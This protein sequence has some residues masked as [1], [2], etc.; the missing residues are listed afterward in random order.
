MRTAAADALVVFGVTGDLAHKKIFPALQGLVRHGM[1]DVPVIG[2][3]RG[4]SGV[5]GLRERIRDSLEASED[6]VDDAA[7]SRLAKLVRYVDG[8][9]R[10]RR[11]SRG[12]APRSA[13]RSTRCITWRCRRACSR[14]RPISSAIPAAPMAPASSSRSRSAAT[15]PRRSN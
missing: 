2:V 6:G 12:C 11:R 9:Y 13:T 3:A 8:D 10:I 7:Y 5:E 14:R 15:W 4:G 1:L